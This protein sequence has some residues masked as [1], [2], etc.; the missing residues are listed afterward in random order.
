VI[1]KKWKPVFWKDHAQNARWNRYDAL[2]GFGAR[3]SGG[4]I[5]SAAWTRP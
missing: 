3:T 2:C 4:A 1:P 5:F